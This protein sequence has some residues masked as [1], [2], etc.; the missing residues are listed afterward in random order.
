MVSA[1]RNRDSASAD[2]SVSRGQRSGPSSDQAAVRR[3]PIRHRAAKD[4]PP[5]TWYALDDLYTKS[6]Q[7]LLFVRMSIVAGFDASE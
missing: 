7:E 5:P 6:L 3:S 4:A 2:G 1:A